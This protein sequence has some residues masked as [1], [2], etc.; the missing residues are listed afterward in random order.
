M[1]QSRGWLQDMLIQHQADNAV[2]ILYENA[3]IHGYLI[4]QTSSSRLASARAGDG[5]RALPF[6]REE[7]KGR[8]KTIE[9]T[10]AQ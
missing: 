2:I 5:A 8:K 6:Q 7:E 4:H 1:I 9:G 3:T 10:A